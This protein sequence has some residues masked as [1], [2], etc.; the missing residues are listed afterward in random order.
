MSRPLE[1]LPIP[2]ARVSE[3]RHDVSSSAD[4]N[5]WLADDVI[6]PVAAPQVQVADATT[7]TDDKE[8][9]DADTQTDPAPLPALCLSCEKARAALTIDENA[10]LQSLQRQWEALSKMFS[11][12]ETACRGVLGVAQQ[13][14]AELEQQQGAGPMMLESDIRSGT[15]RVVPLH[16]DQPLPTGPSAIDA[17]RNRVTSSR[18]G[19][20]SSSAA[21][22]AA[23][24]VREQ[25]PVVAATAHVER[26]NKPLHFVALKKCLVRPAANAVAAVV[27]QDAENTPPSAV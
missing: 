3:E 27:S 17:M 15:L 7:E 21:A 22:V 6:V 8:L 1:M 5:L 24:P 13:R 26:S 12:F 14:R 11:K 20:R 25:R 23:A 4:A 2:V 18:N 9:D 19:S 16:V 10:D